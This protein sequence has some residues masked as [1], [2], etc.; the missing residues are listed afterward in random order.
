MGQFLVKDELTNRRIK[1][2]LQQLPKDYLADQDVSFIE[3]Y[4]HSTKLS[5]VALVLAKLNFHVILGLLDYANNNALTVNE[6]LCLIFCF[7]QRLDS[8]GADFLINCL[9]DDHREVRKQAASALAALPTAKALPYLLHLLFDQESNVRVA[10][11]TAINSLDM[12]IDLAPLTV[13][14]E[15]KSPLVR[16]KALQ[17][18]IQQQD[19]KVTDALLFALQ[20]DRWGIVNEAVKALRLKGDGIATALIDKLSAKGR[21]C[22][23]AAATLL[24]ELK[25][26]A[27]VPMLNALLKDSGCK[28]LRK[29]VAIAL[30]NI[31]DA[32]GVSV[33]CDALGDSVLDVRYAVLTAL[34]KI[35]DPAVIP[36]LH[37]IIVSS[38]KE[39]H[40]D[41]IKHTLHTLKMIPHEQSILAVCD[42]LDCQHKEIKI[43]ALQVLLQLNATPAIDMLKSYY[44]LE[45]DAQLK[46]HYVEVLDALML[47]KIKEDCQSAN[48]HHVDDQAVNAI[49]E[50]VRQLLSNQASRRE[51][52]LNSLSLETLLE[53]KPIVFQLIYDESP[54]VRTALA[55]VC[56]RLNNDQLIDG[57]IHQLQKIPD[58]H[59]VLLLQL[60]SVLPNP[61]IEKAVLYHLRHPNQAI[62]DAAEATLV[63]L[64]IDLSVI[65][66]TKLEYEIS[67]I[68]KSGDSKG[69]LPLKLDQTALVLL[70]E[71]AVDF[72]M[73]YWPDAVR[74][75]S[76]LGW[77]PKTTEEKIAYYLVANDTNFVFDLSPEALTILQRILHCHHDRR[78]LACAMQALMNFHHQ[79]E[80]VLVDALKSPH[81]MVCELAIDAYG[82]LD[83]HNSDTLF[84]L[85]QDTSVTVRKAAIQLLGLKKE[86]KSVAVLLQLLLAEEKQPES[87]LLPQIINA[88]TE[89]NDPQAIPELARFLCN[90]HPQRGLAANALIQLGGKSVLLPLVR[91]LRDPQTGMLVAAALQSIRWQ[92]SRIEDQAYM[93]I[94][95]QDW[96]ALKKL[97]D[98]V[99]PQIL[100]VIAHTQRNTKANLL[101]FLSG[102]YD[103]RSVAAIKHCIG[104]EKADLAKSIIDVLC[105]YGNQV[106]PELVRFSQQSDRWN[107]H[108]RSQ[109]TKVLSHLKDQ[110]AEDMF[111]SLLTDPEYHNRKVAAD[112]L[113]RLKSKKAIPALAKCLT[114]PKSSVVRAAIIALGKIGGQD[115]LTHLQALKGEITNEACQN[116]LDK[117]IER[118]EKKQKT[119]MQVVSGPLKNLKKH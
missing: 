46:V 12:P 89:I 81:K 48:H 83:R 54:K 86:K 74:A 71:M 5:S 100:N 59:L 63:S 111:I 34:G 84:V 75:L 72:S 24:G 92:P 41:L 66:K 25:C 68:I 33:L 109:V 36:F 67:E 10:L 64:G 38:S 15:D 69:L 108:A 94:W 103:P 99:L 97:G 79:P 8:R 78:T 19:E 40:C 6:K 90:Q 91:A 47:I 16:R 13:C 52:A 53:F 31:G 104:T 23:M 55:S 27:A 3:M 61:K 107:C 62:R 2:I 43:L 60:L 98:E 115:A 106:V 65:K 56:V 14:L 113:G 1:S 70:S 96:M 118:I 32:Q 18:I 35:S 119:R 22:K 4:A 37:E 42:A 101:L 93:A 11:L 28:K 112:G 102:K 49:P 80:Q 9:G 21:Y 82:Q 95:M 51:Q 7:E 29:Q 73:N 17:L 26:V 116:A 85:L 114:T 76:Y 44:A 117:A 30:G 20:D 57:L 77:K 88:L 58:N 110:R 39:E 50:L 87:V 45:T 105:S